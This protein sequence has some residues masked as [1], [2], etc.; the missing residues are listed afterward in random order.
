MLSLS[1]ECVYTKD[2]EV[3][4]AEIT[5]LKLST[6]ETNSG[7]DVNITKTIISFSFCKSTFVFELYC[8]LSSQFD[9]SARTTLWS[10]TNVLNLHMKSLHLVRN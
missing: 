4:A 1:V 10:I 2:C 9:I 8:N 5:S 7:K 3:A 6:K